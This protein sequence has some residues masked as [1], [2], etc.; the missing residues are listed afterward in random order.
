MSRG[1][2]LLA[3]ALSFASGI[4]VLGSPVAR[5]A[6]PA[7]K[8]ARLGFVGTESL[9]RGVPAFWE[10]LHELGWLE[11]KNLV[12]ETR[13][14]EGRVEQLPALMN[15]VLAQK[16]DVLFTYGTPAAVAA[17]KATSTVP[18]VA[19]MMGDPLGT[20]LAASLARP[21]GNLTG[22]SLAMAEGLGGKWLQLLHEVVP[23]LSTVAVIGNPA[24]PWVPRMA[25]DLEGAARTRGLALRFI[26]V[27][28]VAGLDRAFA[29]A[30]REAQGAIVLGDPLTLHNW[31]RILS[32]AAKH[33]VPS[34]YPNRES[35][36]FGG[37]MA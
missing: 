35:A 18:I 23:R 28:D 7:D 6:E 10:R 21:G 16:V 15:Q 34:M 2:A 9:S 19:A 20:G 37:L 30:Q 5:A 12:V 3:L 11:G 1:F 33:R 36:E 32:L 24:S 25:K 4:A 17:K 31:Q 27:R 26:E 13:W 22:I 8:V 29:R 14:A